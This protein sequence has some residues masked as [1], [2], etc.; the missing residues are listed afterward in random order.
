MASRES[1]MPLSFT[2][3]LA[4]TCVVLAG[5]FLMMELSAR[6]V[7]AFRVGPS[8]LV[9]GLRSARRE[10]KPSAWWPDNE[11]GRYTKYRPHEIR[12]DKDPETQETFTVTLNSRGFRG[13]EFSDEK[14]PG[15]VRV[16]TLGESSTFGLLARDD[17]TYPHVLEQL[18]N[19][20]CGRAFEV[21]NLGIPHLRSNH[22]LALFL[23]EALPLRPDVITYYQG[24]NDNLPDDADSLAG[25]RR[26]VTWLWQA[27]HDH[28]LT[29]ALID[30]FMA[31]FARPE[32]F[33]AKQ[34]RGHAERLR[35]PFLRNV[36]RIHREAKER[37]IIFI[38]ATQQLRSLLIKDRNDVRGISF[39][40]EMELVKQKLAREGSLTIR[41]RTFYAHGFL[42]GDLRAWASN[43]GVPLVDVIKALDAERDVV[44]NWVHLSRRGNQ[45]I[46]AAFAQEIAR[47]VCAAMPAP[48]GRTG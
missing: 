20:Q 48:Q 23:A 29:V 12:F 27:A 15:V 44:V 10:I 33:S 19:G 36:S 42:M 46:A 43:N 2:K 16:I 8:L 39:D 38:M 11:I 17:E 31:R 34:A 32:R 37:G 24:S 13:K 28:V 35:A 25:A 40:A 45:L 18:L 3:K 6:V 7:Y 30:D 4:F 14:K 21:I 26:H 5:V 22:V 41:E 47:H 1:S 9:Y